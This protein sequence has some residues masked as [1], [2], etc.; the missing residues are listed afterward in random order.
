[1]DRGRWRDR[2]TRSGRHGGRRTVLLTAVAALLLG[3]GSGAVHS[4][5][6]R[7]ASASA[8][9]DS[10]RAAQPMRAWTKFCQRLPAECRVDLTEPESITLT[11]AI[12]AQIV[13]V[14]RDVNAAVRAVPDQAHWG[15]E[16]RW[17]YPDDGIGDCEDIQLLKRKLLAAQG[18]PRRAMR[19]TVVVDETG[20]GHA[21]LMVRTD[22]GDLI[23][24]NKR[25]AVLP[26]TR[27]GY[28]FVKREG[29]SG[30]AWV[31][32]THQAS[33]AVTANR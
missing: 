7:A 3:S 11:P 22:Q 5:V 20:A 23:L 2:G 13:A 33:P 17:D 24:D 1:M 14:N 18:L 10:G 31:W 27:T 29:S 9:S 15:V 25:N 30:T 6:R 4:Q 8:A 12:L 32:I 19:M 26:W 16:D 21:V 28:T